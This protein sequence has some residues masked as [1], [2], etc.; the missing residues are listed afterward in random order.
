MGCSESKPVAD[1]SAGGAKGSANGAANGHANGCP[2][3][4]GHAHHAPAKGA[5]LEPH[6][7]VRTHAGVTVTVN[8]CPFG[9]GSVGEKSAA[10]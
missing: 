1:A 3:H 9:H 2:A 10:Q 5:A 6:T 7:E 4:N 8:T